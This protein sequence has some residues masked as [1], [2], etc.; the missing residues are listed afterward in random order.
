MSLTQ[1]NKFMSSM[2]NQKHALT[3]LRAELE[4]SKRKMC[5]C[6]KKFGHLA[7]NCKNKEGEEKG[8]L[9]P[10]NKF[11]VLASRV[12]RCGVREEVVR[13]QEEKRETS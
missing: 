4:K 13:R 6:Y 8:K 7:Q 1:Y 3:K 10:Q 9:I 2:L 12:M 5:W 11:E